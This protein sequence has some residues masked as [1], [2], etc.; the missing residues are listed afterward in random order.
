[1]MIKVKEREVL[2]QNGNWQFKVLTRYREIVEDQIGS[3]RC[4]DLGK[5]FQKNRNR[6]VG[7]VRLEEMMMALVFVFVFK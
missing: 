6:E 4:P 1:M 7:R 2:L 3:K 5:D